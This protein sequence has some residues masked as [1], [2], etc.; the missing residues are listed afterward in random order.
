MARGARA[1]VIDEAF[2]G[3]DE[4]SAVVIER[5]R[6]Q[7]ETVETL[8]KYLSQRLKAKT[9]VTG[10]E[11]LALHHDLLDEISATYGVPPSLLLS[12]WGVE[13]NFGRF[14]GTRPTV[15]AL[16]TLAWD[17]RRST[18]FHGELLDALDILNRGDIE[19]PKMLGS[20]AGAMG[21]VQFI[22]SSYLKYAEDYDGDGRRDIWSTP[23]DVFAS[24]ANYMHGHGWATGESWGHEVK[25]SADARRTIA[26]NIELRA[27]TCQATRDMTVV[28]PAPR[29]RSLGV[30]T[31]NGKKLSDDAPD[32]ALV[33][34]QS[35][36]FLV[37]RNYDALLEYNCAHSY[38]IGVALLADHIA[39]DDAA[40]EPPAKAVTKKKH[41]RKAQQ[42]AKT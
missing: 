31:M 36:A 8:E 39:S 10:R 4:P 25:I 12:I 40:P 42:K 18:L 29:W 15:A 2:T 1:E 27:G 30:R 7:A 41:K 20:W 32:A 23:A 28:L 9:I 3:I 11:M 26:N 5:D 22:P 35:R 17:P 33:L 37:Y 13:S 6:S 21:Q 38:A 19:F 14:S 24:I 34:G 16:A